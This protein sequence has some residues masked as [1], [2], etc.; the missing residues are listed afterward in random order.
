MLVVP[1]LPNSFADRAL[2]T[3]DIRGLIRPLP[4]RIVLRKDW[5]LNE[6]QVHVFGREQIYIVAESVK[7][8]IAREY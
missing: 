2:L 4:S 5:K 7:E 8:Q 1:D 6:Q 3:V